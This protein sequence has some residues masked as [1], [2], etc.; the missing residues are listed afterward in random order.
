MESKTDK[1][2]PGASPVLPDSALEKQPEETTAAASH[3]LPSAGLPAAAAAV[4]GLAEQTEPNLFT[5]CLFY[6]L[7]ALSLDVPNLVY[8]GFTF[9]QT[10]HFMKWVVSLVPVGIMALCTGSGA[11]LDGKGGPLKIDVLGAYWLLYLVFVTVQPLWVHIRLPE[12]WH[13]EWFFLTG[14]IAFYLTAFTYFREKWLRSILWLASLNAFI[15]GVFA[16]LQVRELI[17]PIFGLNLIM[18]TPNYY[19][20]NTGQQNM[21]GLWVA[22]ALFSSLFLFVCYGNRF[23]ENR[24]N[25]AAI[26]INVVF[27]AALSWF[28]ICSTSRSA[29]L[30]FFVGAFFLALMICLSDHDRGRL[31]R[32]GI[33]IIIFFMVFA[34]F[35]VLDKNRGL[36]FLRK[37]RDMLS[38]LADIGARRQI[39]QTSWQVFLFHPYAGVGLGQFKW[40]YLEGQHIAMIL[41]PTMDWQFTYWAHN[42]IL[43][44]F[45]EFGLWGGLSLLLMMV[46]WLASFVIYVRRHKGRAL[47]LEF[48]WGAAFLFL[49]WFDALWTRPFHRIEN[50]LWIA[51]AFALSSRHLFFGED[52][53]IRLRRI[54]SAIYRL[55]G[56]VFLAA[57]VAGF[58]FG[59]DG[60]RADRLLRRAVSGTKDYEQ[61]K[62]LIGTAAFSPML[63]DHAQR[64]MALLV[65]N[66]GKKRNDS[67]MIADGLNRLIACFQQK[68]TGDDYMTLL[69]YASQ[70]RIESLLKFL[71]PYMPPPGS[72]HQSGSNEIPSVAPPGQKSIITITH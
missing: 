22:L 38:N 39:W 3:E 55:T 13:R 19:I 8:S 31:K 35:L 6:L 16:E 12:G 5:Q 69:K 67:D 46:L 43:Q 52:A 51:L 49:V 18:D 60:F 9:F 54:P 72:R 4:P 11:L 2:L 36:E 64:E 10:L 29:I 33:G 50:A 45:C 30:A 25:K 68:P 26:S 24:R 20:G 44:W 66:T 57:A 41:D 15:N 63:H 14:C 23:G 21:F 1:Q 37:S 70:Y 65:L 34:A 59:I 58:W 7:F 48:T 17:R 61:Q 47:P 27:Y 42:E 56:A 32:L 71:E 40:Y 53:V 62:Q 28:L